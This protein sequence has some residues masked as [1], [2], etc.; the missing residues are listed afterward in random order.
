[1]N[2]NG[3]PIYMFGQPLK[4]ICLSAVPIDCKHN[5]VSL[6]TVA[7]IRVAANHK[8]KAMYYMYVYVYYTQYMSLNVYLAP[9]S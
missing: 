2:R 3:N 1:L 6:L 5:L 7:V 8:Y 9:K 4:T